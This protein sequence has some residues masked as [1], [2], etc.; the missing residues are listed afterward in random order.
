M[1][2]TIIMA[3]CALALVACKEEAPKEEA[4]KEQASAELNLESDTA[5]LSYALG[6]DIGRNLGLEAGDLDAKVFEA[7]IADAASGEEGEMSQQQIYL[8]IRKFQEQKFE[9]QQAVRFA[10]E[11]QENLDFLTENGKRDGVVTLDSGLQYEI[12]VEAEGEKPKETDRVLVN[13]KG[14][15]INGHVFDASERHGGPATFPVNGVIK[16]WV[17]ALQMMPVGSK[18]KLY[19]PYDIAY[20]ARGQGDIP[21]FATLIFETEILEINPQPKPVEP[22]VPEVSKEN[23]A[24]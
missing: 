4:P 3:A 13:Y 16:G 21:P 11:K 7:A 6:Y 17:E 12:M 2:R 14:S 23:A 1:K 22:V 18:W 20:G 9:K 10:K 24:E 15:L 5:Q 8:V 19:I